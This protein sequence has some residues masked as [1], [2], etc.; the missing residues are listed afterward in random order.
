MKNK[1][2]KLKKSLEKQ[3]NLKENLENKNQEISYKIEK[4]AEKQ[5]KLKEYEQYK[6]NSHIPATIFIFIGTFFVTKNI[7]NQEL[8]YATLACLTTSSITSIIT[9]KF[10]KYKIK[11]LKKDNPTIDFENSNI[12]ENLKKIKN[13]LQKQEKTKEKIN[14]IN[15]M[16]NQC[17]KCYQGLLQGNI[18][19]INTCGIIKNNEKCKEKTLQKKLINTLK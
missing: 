13:L 8:I 19:K 10:S 4:L 5:E 2:K 15:E 3:Q 18:E 17:E 1:L 6:N 11:K 14:R 7:L 16:T 9:N 12:D